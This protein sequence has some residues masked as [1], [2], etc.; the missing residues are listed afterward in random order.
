MRRFVATLAV[1]ATSLLLPASAALAAEDHGQG[2]LGSVSDKTVTYAGFIIIA[3]FPLVILLLSLLQG[4]LD[5]RKDRR[6]KAMKKLSAD[7]RGGW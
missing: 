4:G 5:R 3:A 1:L 7:W 2:T 6:K